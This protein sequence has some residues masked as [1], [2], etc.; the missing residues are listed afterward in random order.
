[1]GHMYAPEVNSIAERCHRTVKR[2]A[3]RSRCSIAEAMYWYNA[4]P[5]DNETPSSA[6]ANGIYQYKQH[7]KSIQPK[8]SP[9]KV[10]SNAYQV[11]EPVWVKPPDCRC[12]TRLCK[13][14]V[15]GVISLVNGTIH[16]V[17]Y[18]RR[19]NES[20]VTEDK[21]DHPVARWGSW[22]L[23]NRKANIHLH[24]W[25]LR[26]VPKMK[27]T[28]LVA[29]EGMCETWWKSTYIPRRTTRQKRA[30]PP[31][32]ICDHGIREECSEN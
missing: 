8:P 29:M 25:R 12:T 26:K 27:M 15:D 32:H 31:C 1:M 13:G 9:P 23:V 24:S 11:G 14:Q 28:K 21:S 5:K 18:L 16:H 20:A 7:V 19:C 17:K 2:I 10:R 3:A 22:W 4:T 30:P 6:P